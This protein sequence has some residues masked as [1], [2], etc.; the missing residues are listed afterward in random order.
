MT[1]SSVVTPQMRT[2]IEFKSKLFPAEPGEDAQT[3][4]GIF[5]KKLAEYLADWFSRNGFGV[6]GVIAEDW[7]WCVQ[8]ANDG[9][10]LFLGCGPYQEGEDMWLVFIEPSKP[11]VRRWFKKI[12]TQPVVARV[13]EAL[14][15][16]LTIDGVSSLR[17]WADSE[18]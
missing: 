5:G 14:E 7:G 10:E 4:P 8:L 2:H 16:S 3:N 6:T 9:F 15:Q 11:Y 1:M 12:D 17:W 18:I 13:A